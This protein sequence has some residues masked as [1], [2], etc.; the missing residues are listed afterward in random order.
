MSRQLPLP[1]SL[2]DGNTLDAFLPEANPEALAAVR[3]LIDGEQHFVYLWG[4]ADSGRTHLLEGAADSMSAG[5]GGVAYLAAPLLREAGL[6]V[7]EGVAESAALVCLDDIDQLAG[8]RRWEEAIFHL[9]NTIRARGGRLLCAAAA[10]P[11][12]AKF[13]LPDLAS[14]LA[15][16]LVVRL[17]PLDDEARLAVLAF[18]AGRRGLDLPVDTARYLLTRS[19]RRLADLV[20]LL[21]ELEQA[22]SVHKR[23]LTVPFV[24]QVSGL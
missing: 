11:A 22:A 9:F 6:A 3:S 5:G 16:G 12:T 21:G 24:R 10:P 1:V 2:R 17:S 15:S 18:R 20:A 13:V 8:D 23:R 19:S 4:P 7:L 14:R